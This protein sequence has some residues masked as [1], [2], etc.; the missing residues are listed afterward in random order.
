[1]GAL[2]APV[3]RGPKSQDEKE[4]K[5]EE[6]ERIQRALWLENTGERL[7]EVGQD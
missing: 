2:S 7:E 3:T 5:G 1:M 6:E 4:V